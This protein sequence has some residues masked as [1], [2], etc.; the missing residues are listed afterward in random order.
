MNIAIDR[1]RKKEKVFQ[2]KE[3]N[4]LFQVNDHTSEVDYNPQ[5]PTVQL[6]S[7]Q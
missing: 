1:Q 2:G 3:V 4:S 7:C 5:E 6:F